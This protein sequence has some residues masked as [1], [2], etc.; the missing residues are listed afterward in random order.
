MDFTDR[1]DTVLSPH[2]LEDCPKWKMLNTHLT[3]QGHSVAGERTG[4]MIPE[5]KMFLDGGMNSY[6]NANTI[7]ITH[8]HSDHCHNLPCVA[9][10]MGL[11]TVD[12]AIKRPTVYVPTEIKEPVDIVMQAK[13]ALD[14][15]IILDM[16]DRRDLITLE[17]VTPGQTFRISNL[18]VDV[19]KCIHKVPTVGYLVSNISKKLHKDLLGASQDEIKQRKLNGEEITE[20]RLLPLFAFLGDTTDQ[21]FEENPILFQGV[22][23]IIIECTGVDQK[24]Q[25]IDTIISWGH[26][27]WERLKPII[28]LHKE[29]TF[30][31]IHFSRSLKEA[32][33]YNII[34]E[35]N[36]PNIVL[37]FDS[38]PVHFIK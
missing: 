8:G 33:I 1:F 5:L 2:F 23:I 31:L 6:R 38:G 16:N 22:P 35:S 34:K 20:E 32:A 30:V 3:L 13:R 17:P 28:A 9:T 25:P 24:T 15:S 26:C 12:T 7:L 27:H 19:L 18:Q 10:G 36:L 21:V 11:N 37:W 4:F 29:I 14:N